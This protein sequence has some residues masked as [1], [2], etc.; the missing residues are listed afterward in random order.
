MKVRIGFLIIIL[1]FH[2]FSDIAFKKREL[3]NKF[4]RAQKVN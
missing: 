4:K 1:I 3:K 2:S